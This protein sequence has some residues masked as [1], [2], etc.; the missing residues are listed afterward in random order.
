MNSMATARQSI[1][2][3][4]PAQ[5]S[6]NAQTITQVELMLLLALRGRLHQLESQVQSA[7]Q[8]I[9]QRLE[10][11]ASVEPGDRTATLETS[12]RRNVSWKS[13]AERLADRFKLDGRAFVARVLAATRPTPVVS[14]EIN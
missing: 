14:L 6:P 8:S 13:V 12:F 1:P 5:P 10:K 2:F 3:A 7:E 11:G 9:K 4:V